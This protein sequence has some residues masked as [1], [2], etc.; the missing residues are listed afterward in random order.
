[1]M[2]NPESIKRRE[3][4]RNT[5]VGAA[6]LG[7]GTSAFNVLAGTDKESQAKPK[8]GL[9]GIT[10]LGAWYKGNALSP[11]ELIQKSKNLGFDGIEIDGKRPQGNPLDWPTKKCKDLKTKAEDQGQ[12]IYAVSANNDFSSP[13]PEYRECQIAYMKELIRMTSD[14]GVK[15]LRVFLGWPGITKHPQLARYDIAH[16]IWNFTHYQFTP[17]ET[18]NW[19]REGLVECCKYAGDYGVTLALQNH[20]PVIN[21]C[22]KDV[23]RMVKEV[24][25]PNLKVCL[26][27]PIMNDKSEAN[28]NA[29]AKAVGSL[30]VLTHF[31]GEFA[32]NAEGK[33][34]DVQKEHN[35][36]DSKGNLITENPY[37]HFVKAM[38]DIGYTGYFSYELCHPLPIVNG[39][40]VGIDFVDQCAGLACEMMKG[41]ID[42][43][44]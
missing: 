27:A 7:L 36:V 15:P 9:Y 41:L 16:D 33:I 20:K 37:P 38:K 43:V 1:M 3:F 30:Q 2:S 24:N 13:I 14:L 34:I 4:I 25:S 22:W 32:R 39:E 19:C 17:E 8:V 12:E 28:I 10:Y 40:T 42:N 35:T 29:A 31:G 26:D 11:E 6:A 21:D 23:M 5:A 18:W 44:S